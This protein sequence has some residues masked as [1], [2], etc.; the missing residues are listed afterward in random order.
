VL[1]K[2]EALAALD[3]DLFALVPTSTLMPSAR[4]PLHQLGNL[5]GLAAM[6]RG[7]I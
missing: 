7:S 6:I 3:H 2:A 5:G 4:T 1:A